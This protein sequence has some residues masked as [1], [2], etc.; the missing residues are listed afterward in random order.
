MRKL[1]RIADEEIVLVILLAGFAIV[2]VSAFPPQLLVNDSFLT[3]VGGREVVEHGLPHHDT[4]T[5][6]G[7]GRTWTD[8]QWGAQLL[9]YAAYQLGGHAT[10]ALV[11]AAFVVA[12]F[13]VAAVGARALGAGPRAIVLVFFPVI[14]AA[15]WAWT[16]RAQVFVLPLFTTLVWLLASEARRPSKR[17]YLAIPLLVVWANL[18]GSVALGALLT[19]LLA[20]IELVRTRGRSSR[21]SLPLLVLAP[22]A[23]LATPYGPLVTARYY[24]LMLVHPPFADR[25]TEW[26]PSDPAIDTL[27]FYVLGGLALVVAVWGRKRLTSFDAR[28]TRAHVRRRGACDP[29]HPVVRAVLHGAPARCDRPRAR[30]R[31][32]AGSQPSQPLARGRS[33]RDPGDR[34]RC[35][36]A[37]QSGLVRAQVAERARL[38][39]S[40]A[41]AP[42]PV[43][44]VRDRPSRRLVA[45]E[46]PRAPWSDGI[47]RA[48]RALRIRVLRR[49]HVVQAQDRRGGTSSSTRYRVV[50]VDE[51]STPKQADALLRQPGSRALYRDDKITVVLRPVTS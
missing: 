34:G 25:V 39:R 46:A 51:E 35:S 18:H 42:L 23:V 17:V 20:A 45:L 38:Q 36:L 49:A 26:Q 24:R 4:L 29:R 37:P 22:L 30:G 2:F 14:L 44:C 6:L 47:R 11:A 21:R 10:L 19:M 43:A 13:V 9:A 50:V 28:D 15:P 3:L 12:A 8:Q 27:V 5:I 32:G 1:L 31:R 16:I 41:R 33:R 48:L 40:S 7:A